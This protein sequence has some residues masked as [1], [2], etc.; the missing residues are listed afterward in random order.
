MA[1]DAAK[2]TLIFVRATGTATSPQT[3]H[4]DLSVFHGSSQTSPGRAHAAA[5]SRF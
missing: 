5:A 4:E 2:F 3:F 1:Y